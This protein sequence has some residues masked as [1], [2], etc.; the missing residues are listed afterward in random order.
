[1]Q[2]APEIPAIATA[3]DQDA[4]SGVPGTCNRA[5]VDL[6]LVSETSSAMRPR[7]II[8]EASTG[9][10]TVR[11]GMGRNSS[12]GAV[13]IHPTVPHTGQCSQA[14][15]KDCRRL[16]VRTA[17]PAFLPD[18]RL[19][20]DAQACRPHSLPALRDL[21]PSA[22]DWAW[23]SGSC[24]QS[25]QPP[26]TPLVTIS[27]PG[28]QCGKREKGR[29]P[30]RRWRPEVR[31]ERPERHRRLATMATA[32]LISQRG[33]MGRRTLEQHD[34]HPIHGDAALALEGEGELRTL[35]HRCLNGGACLLGRGI[36]G[37]P[38]G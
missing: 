30:H 9:H 16:H 24:H 12:D 35:P 7:R 3:I 25:R 11:F 15:C 32:H 29:N 14:R 21:S 20:D 6:T 34:G 17:L 28:P 1:M 27:R 38:R 31:W 8:P 18:L 19:P 33:H 23:S 37:N 26:G 10:S 22:G 13:L 36:H 2:L 5:R 4:P